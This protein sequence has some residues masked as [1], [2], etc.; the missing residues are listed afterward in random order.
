MSP[1]MNPEARTSGMACNSSDSGKRCGTVRVAGTGKLKL[2]GGMDKELKEACQ[3]AF[4]YMQT[5]KGALGLGRQIDTS[6]FFVEGVEL[7]GSKVPCSGGVAFFAHVGGF[8]FGLVY[9]WI[10]MRFFPQPPREERREVLYERAQ[11][12]RY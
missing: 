11:R 5:H 12:Y 6:D 3:R 10:F 1:T 8:V 2:S 9:T 4:S 7:L